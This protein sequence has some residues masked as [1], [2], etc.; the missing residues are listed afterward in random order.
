MFSKVT[1]ED[2]VRQFREWGFKVEPGPRPDE[3]TLIIEEP[4]HRCH[5]VYDANMLP[6][7]AAV[8]LEVRWKNGAMATFQRNG[9][10]GDGAWV[11]AG[12]ASLV[13]H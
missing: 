10:A 1:F 9:R 5:M 12:A 7:I 2:A 6:L 4:D 11:P 8:A 13:L 3:V